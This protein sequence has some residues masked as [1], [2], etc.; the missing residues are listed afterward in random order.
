[1]E[2]G[3]DVATESATVPCLNGVPAVAVGGKES[4]GGRPF[5][6]R[7]VPACS[8]LGSV[9]HSGLAKALANILRKFQRSRCRAHLGAM[10][11]NLARRPCAA[12]SETATNGSDTMPM[13]DTKSRAARRATVESTA[14]RRLAAH[15]AGQT[16]P[17][18]SVAMHSCPAAAQDLP[19]FLRQKS[20]GALILLL[21]NLLRAIPQGGHYETASK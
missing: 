12:H 17:D 10:D 18:C 7:A 11:S 9:G 15:G 1:V 6:G 5:S 14:Q 21:D 16:G 13:A 20:C 2:C 3:R 4:T 8:G 19:V